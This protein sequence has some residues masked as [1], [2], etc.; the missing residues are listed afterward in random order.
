MANKRRDSVY[1][2]LAI[3]KTLLPYL[4]S[5]LNECESGQD[6]AEIIRGQL[7]IAEMV[8]RGAFSA[9]SFQPSTVALQNGPAATSTE[10]DS[11]TVVEAAKDEEYT[12]QMRHEF[13]AQ[14]SSM[15]GGLL[16]DD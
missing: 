5:R 2:N 11:A 6:K 14:L 8:Q 9:L 7:L 16:D 12:A 4:H 3:P 10:K 13:E 1:V 15:T